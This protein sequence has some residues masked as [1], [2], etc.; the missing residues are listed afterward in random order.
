VE[1]KKKFKNIKGGPLVLSKGSP[2]LFIYFFL[3][4]H[5]S[6]P[7]P[8][9]FLGVHVG[10]DNNTQALPFYHCQ[11]WSLVNGKKKESEAPHCLPTSVLLWSLYHA[12]NCNN[13]G[14]S[15]KGKKKKKK[16]KPK[17]P[18]SR[19]LI[20]FNGG[21]WAVTLVAKEEGEEEEKKEKKAKGWL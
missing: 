3:S 9:P 19:F 4:L 6:L 5:L 1:G 8:C 14:N 13:Y 21:F 12:T 20:F 11:G 15:I 2:F 17:K 18:T 10:D 16:K 7:S